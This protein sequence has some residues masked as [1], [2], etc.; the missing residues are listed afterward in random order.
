M[1]DGRG[2]SEKAIL[3]GWKCLA[4]S[5]TYRSSLPILSM[6][7]NHLEA[8]LLFHYAVFFSLDYLVYNVLLRNIFPLPS[9]ILYQSSP[10]LT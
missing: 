1:G 5:G 9:D 8:Y 6:S 2:G 7:E 10:S 4:S 3:H